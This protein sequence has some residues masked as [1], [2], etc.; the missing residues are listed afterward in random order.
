MLV[1]VFVTP[2]VIETATLPTMSAPKPTRL[3][4]PP[5]SVPLTLSIRVVLGGVLGQ[6]GWGLMAFGLLFVWVFDAGGA[7]SSAIRF[8]GDL[9][10]VEGVSTGWRR[11]SLSINEVPV[12]ETS[13]SFRSADGY[14]LTGASYQ[15][16]GYVDEGQVLTVEYLPARPTMSRIRGMRGSSGGLSV[17]F[18]F[19]FPIL[20][21]AF[22]VWGTRKGLR[23]RGLMS[24]G[25]LALGRLKTKEP[26][27]TQINN[28]T[29]YRYTFTFDAEGGG[30]YEVVGSSHRT[31][32]LEDEDLERIVYDPRYPSEARLLDDLPCR[33][34]IDAR[35]DF[36][37]ESP[38]EYQLAAA[39]LVLPLLALLEYAA[40]LTTR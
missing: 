13:Y 18:V 19:L 23:A 2:R 35:G 7:L 33:P 6:L 11:T 15:T 3:S 40:Y 26:T 30:T 1:L 39:N 16:G 8:A 34:A 10:T 31:A 20:G 32:A 29:V 4:P 12:Y 5:R 21:M 38:R 17:S 24:T 9:A 27:N 25:Q 22:V 14:D 28:Q 37:A 36:D